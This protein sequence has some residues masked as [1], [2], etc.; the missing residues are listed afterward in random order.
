LKRQLQPGEIP[1]FDQLQ[2]LEDHRRCGSD[3]HRHDDA[4]VA[5]VVVRPHEARR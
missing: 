2:A 3:A 5:L 4:G 1:K